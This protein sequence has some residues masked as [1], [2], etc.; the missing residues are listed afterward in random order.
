M[1]DIEDKDLSLL[2]NAIDCELKPYLDGVKTANKDNASIFRKAFEKHL[3]RSR[4]VLDLW[5]SI[6]ESKEGLTAISTMEKQVFELFS[7]LGL[8]E[9]LGNCYVDILVMLLVANGK[10]FHIESMH[11]TPRIKHVESIDDLRESSLS[12]RTKLNFLKENGLS[13]FSSLVDSQLRNDI[14]HLNFRVVNGKVLIRNKPVY[15]IINPTGKRIIDAIFHVN[16]LLATL[17][18]EMDWHK[19]Q[20][21]IF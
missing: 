18:F 3:S 10:T 17:A 14:A 11:N 5:L 15:A 13:V 2:E 21:K 12:L 19:K 8:V 1:T 7:Y 4:R 20:G 9:S 6:C 16:G